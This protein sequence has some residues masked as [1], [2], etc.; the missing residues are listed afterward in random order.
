MDLEVEIRSANEEFGRRVGAAV[1]LPLTV[2]EEQR[3]RA[4]KLACAARQE[5]K[6]QQAAMLEEQD[7]F[8]AF[9]MTDYE[10]QLAELQA[11]LQ[12][13]EEQIERERRIRASIP[14]PS[15]AL[16]DSDAPAE[17]AIPRSRAQVTSL[18]ATLKDV[19]GE[20]D[21]T[22]EEVA[23]LEK[24]LEEARGKREDL[25]FEFHKELGVV[26]DEVVQLR[27]QLDESHRRLEDATTKPVRRPFASPKSSTRLD[28]IWTSASTS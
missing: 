9:L 15:P 20:L 19:Y 4:L 6:Q 11:R 24:Q 5:A 12:R 27:W 1:E 8:I 28:A 21:T 14:P 22:R 17:V 23:R 2:L 13:A 25:R 7:R 16:V 3:N 26:Q 18:R 10:R